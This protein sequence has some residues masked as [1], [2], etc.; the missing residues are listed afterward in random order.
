MDEAIPPHTTVPIMWPKTNC[1]ESIL[2]AA[3]LQGTVGTGWTYCPEVMCCM[4]GIG[5]IC[6]KDSLDGEKGNG[7]VWF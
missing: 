6:A 2:K 5:T 7:S 3:Q 1:G 4:A